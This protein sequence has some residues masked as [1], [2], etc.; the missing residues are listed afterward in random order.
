[1]RKYLFLFVFLAGC[2]K[3]EPSMICNADYCFI[4]STLEI[5]ERVGNGVDNCESLEGD[6]KLIERIV[7]DYRTYVDVRD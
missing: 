1:M 7:G 4:P 5:C 6:E 2:G 3:A